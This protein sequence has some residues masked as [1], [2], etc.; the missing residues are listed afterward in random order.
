MSGKKII[1]VVV[2]LIIFE[3]PPCYRRKSFLSIYS[4]SAYEIEQNPLYPIPVCCRLCFEF[5]PCSQI[6]SEKEVPS[7][8]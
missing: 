3:S 5:K 2:I 1:V 7:S 8:S 4:L 6:I